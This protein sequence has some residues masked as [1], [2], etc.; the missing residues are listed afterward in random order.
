M[1]THAGFRQLCCTSAPTDYINSP[2]SGLKTQNTAITSHYSQHQMSGPLSSMSWRF[3]SH[4]STWPCGCQ[5]GIPLR[6]FTSSLSTMTYLNTWMVWCELWKRRSHDERKTYSLPWSLRGRG[7]P[8]IVLQSLQRLIC[9]SFRHIFLILSGSCD[10]F[11]S[12]TR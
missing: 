6:Y 5:F 4:S 2:A 8:N 12:W 1:W 9:T 7:C 10:S 11:G 3:C